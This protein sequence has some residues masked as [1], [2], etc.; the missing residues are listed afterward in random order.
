MSRILGC[1]CLL[2][3]PGLATADDAQALTGTWKSV[4]YVIDGDTI[5]A[6][7]ASKLKYIVKGNILTMRG[8]LAQAGGNYIPTVSTVSYK[9]KLG[10][11]NGHK[12]ID[13]TPTRGNGKALRGI[14]KLEEGKL[15]L[16]LGLTGTRPTSFDSPA[17]SAICLTTCAKE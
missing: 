10:T 13:L 11:S 17:N 16:C 9:M 5:P 4:S 2:L 15:T 14:Y 12:T 6:D 1:L 3:L 8:G 7:V